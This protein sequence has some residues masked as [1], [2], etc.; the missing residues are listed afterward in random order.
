MAR[1]PRFFVADLPLHII[2]RGNN[3]DPIFGCPA[4]FAF[5][6]ERLAL[7]ARAHGRFGARLCPDDEP[8]ASASHAEPSDQRPRE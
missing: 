1:L 3:R 5:L 4:D 6:Y 8:F 2:Q 7:A